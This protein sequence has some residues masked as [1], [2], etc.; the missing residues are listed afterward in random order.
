M[1]ACIERH[2]WCSSLM[3]SIRCPS[4]LDK[5]T[6]PCPILSSSRASTS[7]NSNSDSISLTSSSISPSSLSCGKGKKASISLQHSS[8]DRTNDYYTSKRIEELHERMDDIQI[9]NFLKFINHHL[10]LRKDHNKLNINDLAKDLSNGHVLIDLIEILSSTKLKRERGHTRFHSLTNVQI[11]LDY[12]RARMPHM[13]ILAHEIVS[14]NRKQILALLWIIMKIFDFPGFRLTNKNCFVENTLLGFGQDRSIIIKWLNNILNHSLNTIQIYI[15]DFYLQTWINGYYLSI[16]IKYLIPLSL[17]YLTMECFDYLKELENIHSQDKQ[18]FHLCLTLSNYCFDTITLIDEND[19]SERC[20]FRYFTELQHNIINILKTNHINKLIQNNPYTKQILDTVTQTTISSTEQSS[21]II[22]SNEEYLIC[23]EDDNHYQHIPVVEQKEFSMNSRGQSTGG[24]H[25]STNLRT[26]EKSR[27]FNNQQ[28]NNQLQRKNRWEKTE[29]LQSDLPIVNGQNDTLKAEQ[30]KRVT[31]KQHSVN[32]TPGKSEQSVSITVTNEQEKEVNQFN[33]ACQDFEQIILKVEE[34]I[35]TDEKDRQRK[36]E[37]DQPILVNKENLYDDSEKFEE[38]NDPIENEIS[39]QSAATLEEPLKLDTSGEENKQYVNEFEQSTNAIKEQNESIVSNENVPESDVQIIELENIP[40]ATAP[41]QFST[42]TTI[43]FE[44]VQQPVTTTTTTNEEKL[45]SSIDHESCEQSVEN[46]LCDYTNVTTRQVTHEELL[47][48]AMPELD[49]MMTPATSDEKSKPATIEESLPVPLVTEGNISK[50]NENSTSVPVTTNKKSS[51]SATASKKT[52][53]RV[54]NSVNHETLQTHNEQ[55]QQSTIKLEQMEEKNTM[56]TIQTIDNKPVPMPS[57][58]EQAS[59]PETNFNGTDEKAEQLITETSSRNVIGKENNPSTITNIN[60]ENPLVTT[61]FKQSIVSN[62]EATKSIMNNK[63]YN[64]NVKKSPQV[65][66][67]NKENQHIST[68]N[69]QSTFIIKDSDQSRIP[70]EQ[71]K[72]NKGDKS[73]DMITTSSTKVNNESVQ[74]AV[75]LNKQE[76]VTISK[77][78][79]ASPLVPLEK[80]KQTIVTS[81]AIE[82]ICLIST[83]KKS[84]QSEELLE[85]QEQSATVSEQPCA[86]VIL[87]KDVKKLSPKNKKSRRSNTKKGNSSVKTENVHETLSQNEEE[88]FESSVSPLKLV[89]IVQ[90]QKSNIIFLEDPNS[91]PILPDDKLLQYDDTAQSSSALRSRKHKKKKTVTTTNTTIIEKPLSV[92]TT[93]I[94][95]N[96]NFLLIIQEFLLDRKTIAFKC[97]FILAC[98]CVS[99]YYYCTLA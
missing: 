3:S 71:T 75:S 8:F 63:K 14:G 67:S 30:V 53:K 51:T 45:L 91:L 6:K 50:L 21:H 54:N 2:G 59:Q 11:V 74:V 33:V 73:S 26:V 83:N 86:S 61:L 48:N 9:T 85:K 88:N 13:N 95:T 37:I 80:S 99:I 72:V 57:I 55:S 66:S 4:N 69:K 90:E 31:K 5:S 46:K 96:R 35:V 62:D 1:M 97:V 24:L 23:V 76:H 65:E 40:A 82:R 81:E 89:T 79:V 34:T 12:L 16:I 19:R 77:K 68:S 28:L 44:E 98:L 60:L 70:S 52:K 22:N 32:S 41:E 27:S 92:A 20:L 7:M 64:G 47:L 29:I 93:T 25:Q 58:N 18:R 36:V 87:H 49:M 17:K 15:H 43:E 56:E 10:S 42:N 94:T 38:I 78:Q 39:N 84:D